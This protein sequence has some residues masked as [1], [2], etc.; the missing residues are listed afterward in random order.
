M[1]KVYLNGLREV[2]IDGAA[3]YDE[4]IMMLNW[5]A[6]NIINSLKS[7]ESKNVLSLGIG[8]EIVS[9]LIIQEMLGLLDE[10]CI[11]EGSDEIIQHFCSNHTD[12]EAV[13]V[14]SCMFEDFVPD[15]R[16][17]AIEMGFVL[18]HV[19]NPQK[20]LNHY[21]SLL[22]PNGIIYIAV[23]N[24]KSLHRLVGNKAGLLADIYVLSQFDLDAGHKRYFDLDS[25]TALLN[26]CQLKIRKTEGIFL[27]PISSNQIEFLKLSKE[28]LNGFLEIARDYPE[29]SNA[30]Y[31]EAHR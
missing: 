14:S 16:F 18:E 1:D 7:R 27:K 21:S 19:D 28:I 20:I 5:Y 11:V 17:D 30:I 15:R 29:I 12:L 2:Y 13:K 9:S 31:I 10:Y 23:P 4:N 22:N 26:Q 8:H 3:F 25:L 24:A 6:N